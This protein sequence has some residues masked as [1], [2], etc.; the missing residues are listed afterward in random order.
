MTYSQ[1]LGPGG[2]KTGVGLL[3]DLG[4]SGEVG[5]VDLTL[6]GEPDRGGRLRHRDRAARRPRPDARRDGHRRRHR[7]SRSPL[8]EPPPAAS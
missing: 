7:R 2:L 5:E 3:L 1:Q 8:D 4:A 6:V